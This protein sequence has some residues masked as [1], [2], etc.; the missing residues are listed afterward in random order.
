MVTAGA[1]AS[2]ADIRTW[3]SAIAAILSALAA[4]WARIAAL[5]AH[6]AH[7]IASATIEIVRNGN[8][9]GTAKLGADGDVGGDT[10]GSIHA[11]P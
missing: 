4:V 9:N 11:D 5:W 3:L 10:G 2:G 8:G 1:A 7:K 6:R